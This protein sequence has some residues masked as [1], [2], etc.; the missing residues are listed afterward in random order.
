MTADLPAVTCKSPRSPS[1]EGRSGEMAEWLKAHAWKACVRETVPWVRIPLSPPASC[2][3]KGLIGLD[4]GFLKVL[5][6]I[7]RIKRAKPIQ[8]SDQTVPA[9]F[10]EERDASPSSSRTISIES[11]PIAITTPAAMNMEL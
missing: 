1:R 11:I 7:R 4:A 9:Y 3:N 6:R 8:V 10:V 5:P 2:W